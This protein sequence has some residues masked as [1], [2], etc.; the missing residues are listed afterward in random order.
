[1][2]TPELKTRKQLT[3][4]WIRRFVTYTNLVNFFGANSVMRAW[5]ESDAGLVGDGHRLY[6]AMLRRFTLLASK[7][8]HLIEVAAERGVKQLGAQRSKMYVIIRPHTANVDDIR[9]VGPDEHIEIDDSSQFAA[10]D[11]IR[12]RNGDGTVTEIAVVASISVGT[13]LINGNDELVIAGG[14]TLAYT[15]LIDDVDVLKRH[16]VPAGTEI[17]TDIGV[18]FQTIDEVAVGDANPIF[19]G[20]STHLSLADKALCEATVTGAVTNVGPGVVTDF[21]TPIPEVL[22]VENPE[23]ATGGAD[24]EQDFDL[25]YRTAHFPTLQNQETWSWLETLAHQAN[26]N[27]LRAQRATAIAVGAV[28]TTVLHRNGSGFTAAERTEAEA[29]MADRA[30]S[31]MV[32]NLRN[33]VLTAVEVE[34]K[35][36]LEPDAVLET[37]WKEASSRLAAFLDYRKWQW[38][39]DVDEADLLSVVKGTPGVA[40]LE[41]A[42]FLPAADVVVAV[43]SLP[44][45]ARVSLQDTVSGETINASLA[46]SF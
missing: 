15:P 21:T 9:V 16:T 40:T 37:V 33:I 41:T 5:A 39:G 19:D 17:S 25:K 1:V 42:A 46:V 31:H 2:S 32:V 3:Q 7:G 11:S 18:S 29:F 26:S 44:V 23:R 24:I 38:G 35:I 34:A 6:S 20:E 45:L 10:A 14:L 36:T 22:S 4:E 13:G 12:V 8:A 43:T 28:D 27:V 30:R